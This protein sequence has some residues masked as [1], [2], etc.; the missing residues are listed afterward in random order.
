MMQRFNSD[1]DISY[2][3]S[4]MGEEEV[5]ELANLDD[6]GV[7]ARSAAPPQSDHHLDGTEED[8]SGSDTQ[9][10][11]TG[12]Q[13][14]HTAASNP[15]SP[16][17]SQPVGIS[18][19]TEAEAEV[20]IERGF[21]PVLRNT[22]FL[23]LWSGQVFSQL[24]DKVYLVLMIMIITTQIQS[25]G[26]T[27]SGWVSS[28]MVAFTIP[29][30]LFGSV[31]G[32]FVDYWPKKGVLVLTN[33]LRGVL[34]LLLPLLLG[35]AGVGS[36]AGVPIDFGVLL[37]VTF[38]VSTL[39]QFFSPAEQAIIPLLVERRHLLSANS[40]YTTTMMASVIIG[41]AVGEPLLGLADRVI[42][43]SIGAGN[44]GKELLVGGS[45]VIAAVLLL[46]IRPHEPSDRPHREQPPVWQ[47]IRD[48]VRYLNSQPRV[49]A[50]LLQ[51]VMLFSIFAALAVLAV[52]MAEVMPTLASSQF[53][54][55]LAAGGIGM[56]LGA[57]L[58]GHIGHD[59]S[60]ER[61]SFY[62]AIGL[63]ASLAVLS[64][65]TQQLVPALLTLVCL[66][67]SAAAV[68]VPLQTTI[69]EQTPEDMRGKVFGLQNNAVN[70]ALSLP[71]ALAGIAETFLGL[72][73]VFLALAG[74]AIASGL[75]TFSL[76][77]KS[78]P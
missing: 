1:L 68:G 55:L 2:K 47:E 52:R 63:G 62:G 24:A 37:A 44:L 36:I 49:R 60:R 4:K 48:G 14:G 64:L 13:N 78:S 70:I 42:A 10:T 3:A 41:F 45:Y 5:C 11:E 74:L 34:V 71:L 67:A 20:A 8:V 56:G 72:R 66:G 43:P 29:A 23:S 15:E 19:P 69:Q 27:V 51:L 7:S 16:T 9:S 50:A 12:S 18:P 40:L 31:A 33:L 38:L 65:F 61:L 46:L 30:V 53:G 59:F 73:V 22:N 17:T 6:N 21:W 25:T 77:R 35:V 28:I 57:L 75:F 39:T 32:V 54:F 76:S 26:Q 58:V